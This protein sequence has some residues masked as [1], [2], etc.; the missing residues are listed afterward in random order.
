MNKIFEQLQM[1]GIIPVVVIEDAKNA[2]PLAQALCEGGLPCAEITFRTDAA[3]E[4]IQIMSEKFPKMLV[5]A[6]TVLTIEQASLAIKAGAKFIVSPGF[7]PKV[8]NYCIDR[9]IPIIPGT[10][11]PS[12]IEKA[13]EYGLDAVK[14]FPAET[15]GGIAAI[16]AMAAAYTKI[17]FVPTGGINPGNLND[18]LSFPKILACGGSWMVPGDL[19][20]AGQFDVI[21]DL[22]KNAVLLMLGFELKHIGINSNS[23]E[24]AGLTTQSFADIFGL[25]KTTGCSSSFAGTIMEAMNTNGYGDKG[26]IAIATNHVD[27]AMNYLESQNVE[28][29]SSSIKRKDG[30]ATLAYLKQEFGGFAVHL[31]QK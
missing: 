16:K 12:D 2:A 23:A 4:A 6:G 22:T 20:R 11:T 31:T 7:N 29:I 26:H 8:V 25:K 27:R 9:N 3:E 13:I 19:I 15:N 1:I 17:K 24:E 5:G 28:F 18:Y 21:R 10:A 30:I 14:F